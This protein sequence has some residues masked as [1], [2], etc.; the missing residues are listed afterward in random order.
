MTKRI[1]LLVFLLLALLAASCGPV[2][3]TPPPE[4]ATELA[5]MD[6]RGERMAGAYGV[7]LSPLDGSEIK[8]IYGGNRLRNYLRVSP[9]GEWVLFVEFTADE[10]GDGVANEA[11]GKSAE[12]G[13]MHV[14]GSGERLLTDYEGVDI[15]PAWSP[16][17]QHVVFASDRDNEEYK[18]DLFVMDRDGGNVV[19]ITNTPNV[20]EAEPGWGDATIAFVRVAL[21]EG[22]DRPPQ[23][24]AIW[25]IDCDVEDLDHC[26]DNVRQ[27]TFPK[28]VSES[29][30]YVFG[31]SSPRFSPDGA[32]VAFH[33]RQD[34]AWSI[35]D[36][37]VGDWDIIII[38]LEDGEETLVSQ[39]TEA[40][41][42]PAWSPDG[43]RL[44]FWVIAPGADQNDLSN[45]NDLYV[46]DIDGGNRRKV[47]GRL[48][49][50]YEQMPDWVPASALG[51]NEEPW[52]IYSAQWVDGNP[53]G[54]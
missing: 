5:E 26:G 48:D 1:A 2:P 34:A 25:A 10:N 12:I 7:F 18:Y 23:T 45:V 11:D 38:A 51:D 4:V 42:M 47:E 3:P 28:V 39:G 43:E 50:L 36:V 46:M 49:L 16:D 40:D 52:L 17:G 6:R 9:D 20:I 21:E 33:R 30:D 15:T 19:N 37:P 44:A 29:E 32:G 27:L 35:G 53:E 8:Q 14:D 13:V 24:Q 54:D 22:E 41:F 31:D